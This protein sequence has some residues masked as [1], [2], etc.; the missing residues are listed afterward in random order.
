MS[1]RSFL[2]CWSLDF[3][4]LEFVEGFNLDN[5]VGVAV[6]LRFLRSHGRFPSRA[7]DLGVDP[8]V[9]TMI[10]S[11]VGF[12]GVLRSN[13]S[14]HPGTAADIRDAVLWQCPEPER[15]SHHATDPQ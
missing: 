6:Q 9:D 3:D 10:L 13:R 5:R 12:G 15:R 4:D 7:E 8:N 14:L 11:G 2:E 1:A